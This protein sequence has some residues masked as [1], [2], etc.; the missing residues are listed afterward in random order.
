MLGFKRLMAAIG[1]AA[2]TVAGSAVPAAAAPD[3]VPGSFTIEGSGY[4]HGVGMAQYGAYQVSRQ[5]LSSGQILRHYYSGASTALVNTPRDIDVQVYGPDP[6]DFAGYGDSRPTRINVFDGSWRLLARGDTIATGGPGDHLD[7]RAS[8][9]DVFVRPE[10]QRERH[11]AR[12]W[13]EWSGTNYYRPNSTPAVVRVVRAHGS[14]RWGRLQL[15]ASEGVPNIANQARLNSAYLY[16]LAE[17]PASWGA[18]SGRAALAAQTI[19]AR[20]YALLKMDEWKERCTCHVVDDVRDQYFDGYDNQV[21]PYARYWVDAVRS[22]TE[23]STRGRVLT[24]DGRAVEAHYYSSSGRG[25]L[26][27]GARTANS[28]D[29]WSSVI[30]YERSVADPYSLRAPGNGNVSWRRLITQERAQDLFGF[31]VKSVGS[32]RVTD[33]FESGQARTL[34]ATS[35]DGRTQKVISGKADYIRGIVGRH[36]RAGSLPAAWITRT[37]AN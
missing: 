30:P 24:H 25:T 3:A 8:G 9:G 4:G 27:S 21:G 20:A 15:T 19:V 37:W 5:G 12:M 18:T 22:T 13:L 28:E 16:G 35:A 7:V 34:V 33:R 17:M 10:G 14:Y 36:T 23:S 1:T 29:V 32:I 2:V 11:F 26:S 31:D 6:Y